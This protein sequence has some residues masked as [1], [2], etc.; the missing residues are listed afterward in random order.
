MSILRLAAVRTET[1]LPTASLYEQV[2]AGTFTTPVRISARA[3]GWPSREVAAIT[4]A[5]IAGYPDDR[6]RELVAH[7]HAKRT[8][9]LPLEV[10]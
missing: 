2:R 3:V 8:A 4:A 6:L 10:L 1:G 5:R 7:L 9:I